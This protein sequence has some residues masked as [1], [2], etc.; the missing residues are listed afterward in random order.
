MENVENSSDSEESYNTEDERTEKCKS[1]KSKPDRR[2]TRYIQK[3]NSAWEAK[4]SWLTKSK[5]D[6]IHFFCKSC[7]IDYLGGKTEIKRHEIS[8]KH[9]L[10]CASVK[11]QRNLA[12]M[13]C[14]SSL[15]DISEGEIRIAAFI[16]EHN[17]PFTVADHIPNL[18]RSICKD[19]KIAVNLKCAKT[20]C[21]GIIKNVTGGINAEKLWNFLKVNKFS[22]IIDESTDK[23]CTKH[24]VL[25]VRIKE[26]VIIKDRFLTLIPMADATA[27]SI[28]TSIKNIFL[29]NGIPYQ[30]N[31]IGLASDGANVMVGT[32]HSVTKLLKEEIPNLFTLNC[33][34]HSF[35]LCAS[36]ACN[37]LP[38]GVE[39]F[40]R[41]IYKFFQYSNK[42]YEAYK[43][44]Q[45][46]CNL[47]PHKLLRPAQT[48]WLSLITVVK[49]ILEQW[50]AL[51]LFFRNEMFEHKTETVEII[52]N[53]MNNIFY[54]LYLMFLDFVLPYLTNLNKEMQAEKP[55]IYSLYSS[56]ELVY[57][58]ILEFIIKDSCLV[59]SRNLFEINYKNPHNL[60][61]IENL[62][63]GGACMAY[64]SSHNDIPQAELQKFK[65][66]CL[67][68]YQ[69]ILDQ[70]RLR[71]SFQRNEL[72]YMNILLPESVVKKKNVS[73][74]PLALQFP[75]IIN[76]TDFNEVDREWRLLMNLD[77]KENLDFEFFWNNICSLKNGVDEPM[78]PLI[79]KLVHH[80]SLL[81]HSSAAAERIFSCI[82]LNK[83]KLRNKLSTST[84]IG[85][86]HT[87]TLFS[88]ESFCYNFD[89]DKKMHS[90]MKTKIIYKHS[91]H[92]SSDEDET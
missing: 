40:V 23:G 68:F 18:M 1:S 79:S 5:K 87:K 26:S 7:Q 47:K 20:K 15:K 51:K 3:Y 88:K 56:V 89:V 36:Y 76:E 14:D 85:I 64:I 72:K 44:F 6:N 2:K 21:T 66:S 31:L 83:T 43:E 13:I 60:I 39:Q 17:L 86:V 80:I 9:Q 48:R 59:E 24:L 77:L 53:K 75:H 22:L 82:N 41:E 74:I 29:K 12:E 45:N 4:Y 57:K 69:E 78:F 10:T 27:T 63:L 11:S 81:P 34:C 61:S 38:E 73:I 25:V 54:K 62:H 37:K 52:F 71:F 33:I 35:A 16:A 58:T 42:K 65:T 46:F 55:K 84:L 19:S 8:K 50:E 92:T 70:I 67:A 49:R 90:N 28:F 91:E 30:K 32:N